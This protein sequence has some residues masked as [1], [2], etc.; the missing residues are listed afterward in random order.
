MTN[1]WF[2]LFY[3][4][5][6][7]YPFFFFEFGVRKNFFLCPQKKKKKKNLEKIRNIKK[8]IHK[9]EYSSKYMRIYDIY[10][11]IYNLKI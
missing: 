6:L 7:F 3:L 10:I 4:L 9:L 2:C 8:I 5:N 11:C 1:F